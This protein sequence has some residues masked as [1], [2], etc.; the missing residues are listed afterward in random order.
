LSNFY[1]DII[2]R[3]NGLPEETGTC[4]KAAG[5]HVKIPI[6]NMANNFS[7]SDLN[8]IMPHSSFFA[9][10]KSLVKVEVSPIDV[11]SLAD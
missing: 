5:V 11:L 4:E 6:P 1:S 2:R 8:F 10:T 3:L 9:L 7:C